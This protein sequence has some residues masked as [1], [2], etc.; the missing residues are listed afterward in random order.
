MGSN[1]LQSK[2]GG[3]MKSKLSRTFNGK[4]YKPFDWCRTKREA[5]K[6]KREQQK[7]GKSVRVTKATEGYMLWVR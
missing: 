2:E 1:S 4:S 7:I 6:E 3:K 5:I